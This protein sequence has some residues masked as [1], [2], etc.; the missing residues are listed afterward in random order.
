M[1]SIDLRNIDANTVVLGPPGNAGVL[2][3][4]L[5]ESGEVLVGRNGTTPVAVGSDGSLSITPDGLS[6][7]RPY[8]YLFN[9]DL[10]IWGAGPAA[11]PTGWTLGGTGASAAKGTGAG[12]VAI[13]LA[14]AVLTRGAGD[15]F[16]AQDALPIYPPAA[17][18]AGKTITLGCWVQAFIAGQA[19]LDLNDGVT[20]VSSV[21][22]SGSGAWEFLTVTQTVDASP[23]QIAAVLVVANT[24]VS[25]VR[26]DGATLVMGSS[27]ADSV[28]CGWQGRTAIL[29]LSSGAAALSA[30]PSYYGLGASGADFQ[31]FLLTPFKG[32]AR[33]L[34]VTRAGGPAT[35]PS[36]TLR[37][38]SGGAIDTALSAAFAST[39]NTAVDV[40]HEVEIAKGTALEIKTTE[41]GNV[42]HTALCEYEEIP[43][44]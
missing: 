24:S 21:T 27:L 17:R 18:W 23:T 16:I 10:E 8:N 39:G 20:I 2:Q 5:L 1:P 14:S 22:H 9:G 19:R 7:A 31:Y 42:A 41:T 36:D 4:V 32:V 37:V 29:S 35:A 40:T 12:A 33:N 44:P 6:V 30:N 28:P 34:A 26:F 11:A 25:A 43:G 13:G 3:S 38:F 15:G